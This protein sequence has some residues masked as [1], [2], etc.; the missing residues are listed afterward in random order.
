MAER[1][2]DQLEIGTILPEAAREG[3]AEH[4][5]MHGPTD[6][7]GD[8]STDQLEDRLREQRLA[9]APHALPALGVGV[10]E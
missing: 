9:G 4:V 1:L 8:R 7:R 6:D 2:L 5:R 10:D 3:M